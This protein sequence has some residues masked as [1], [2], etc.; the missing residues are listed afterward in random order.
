MGDEGVVA[1]RKP[2]LLDLP[3]R[4]LELIFNFEVVKLDSLT[5]CKGLLPYTERGLFKAVTLCGVRR[6]KQFMAEAARRPA[7]LEMVAQ[8]GYSA[9]SHERGS[10]DPLVQARLQ[11]ARR[12]GTSLAGAFV[13]PVSDKTIA[14]I[15]KVIKSLPNLGGLTLHALSGET[16]RRV[17]SFSPPLPT[18]GLELSVIFVAD[19][20]CTQPGDEHLIQHL[21][22]FQS[23]DYLGIH[24]NRSA[25][26]PLAL[27]NDPSM[28]HYL[29]PRS[30]DVKAIALK[31]GGWGGPELRHLFAALTP[32]L[33]DI[34]LFFVHPSPSFTS[35]LSLLPSSLTTLSLDIGDQCPAA[36]GGNQPSLNHLDLV[37]V[38]SYFPCL[39]HLSI[40]GNVVYADA[41]AT[42]L[43]M[44]HLES[45]HLGEHVAITLWRVRLY[46]PP[47]LPK[48]KKLSLSLCRGSTAPNR[49]AGSSYQATTTARGPALSQ[50]APKLPAVAWSG[51]FSVSD[52]KEL[53]RIAGDAG[54]TVEGTVRCALGLC[55]GTSE[56]RAHEKICIRE[57]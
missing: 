8:F 42:I 57:A 38:L 43:R 18:K 33:E 47:T 50:A 34:A 46:L 11:Q 40:S 9:Y 55:S 41:F 49:R 39:A 37:T 30:W 21:T 53:M 3:P 51:M 23:L 56:K 29:P 27:V 1:V 7:V 5:I 36:C 20:I 26:L 54:V 19:D 2:G 28:P 32:T 44:T 10:D 17:L 31:E 25:H 16:V 52:A 4:A 45:L 6:L 14:R 22:Q 24:L 48:F 35:D 15:N 13:D 12:R